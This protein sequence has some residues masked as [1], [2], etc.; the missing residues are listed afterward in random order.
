MGDIR[1]LFASALDRR[2]VTWLFFAGFLLALSGNLVEGP[3]I[4]LRSAIAIGVMLAL[5]PVAA[6]LFAF[7]RVIAE[8]LLMLPLLLLVSLLH[9]AYLRWRRWQESSVVEQLIQRSYGPPRS[10]R[11]RDGR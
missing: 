6:L 1:S 10:P 4:G 2:L 5:I 3:P 7:A 9:G 11:A 8:L